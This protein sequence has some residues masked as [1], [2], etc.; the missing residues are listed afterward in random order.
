MYSSPEIISNNKFSEKS[1]AWALGVILYVLCNQ[2]LPFNEKSYRRLIDA[3]QSK[4]PEPLKEGYAKELGEIIFGLLEKDPQKRMSVQE[5]LEHPW[6]KQQL[7]KQNENIHKMD[8]SLDLKISAKSLKS[9]FERCKM[10]N[11]SNFISKEFMDRL[12]NDKRSLTDSQ[13]QDIEE[14]LVLENKNDEKMGKEMTAEDLAWLRE[15]MSVAG[16]IK[17]STKNSVKM[18][19]DTKNSPL[20]FSK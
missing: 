13:S 12:E 19:T 16:S 18:S 14:S 1:D 11:N 9:D 3:I 5:V 4:T 8:K 2:K 15:R 10:F 6:L 20:S 17:M 7:T